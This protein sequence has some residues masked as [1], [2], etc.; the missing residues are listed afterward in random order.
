MW[1]NDSPFIWPGGNNP[2]R[3]FLLFRLGAK[4]VPEPPA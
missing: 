4:H 1:P 3:E 2:D